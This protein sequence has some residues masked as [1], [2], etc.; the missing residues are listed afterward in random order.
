MQCCGDALADA[1]VSSQGGKQRRSWSACHDRGAIVTEAKSNGITAVPKLLAMLSLK[2]AIVTVDAL[3]CQR[4]IARPIVD[5]GGDCALALIAEQ[6]L[7]AVVQAVIPGQLLG[8]NASYSHCQ[9]LPFDTQ[10]NP[11]HPAKLP[12]GAPP[13]GA[14]IPRHPATP[15]AR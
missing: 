4:D 9:R 13:Q 15:A 3:G 2:S 5:R 10:P 11:P 8:A 1:R 12:R 6:S 14:E 7:T